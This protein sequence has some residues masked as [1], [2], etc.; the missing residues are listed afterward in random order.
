MS[1]TTKCGCATVNNEPVVVYE[2]YLTQEQVDKIKSVLDTSN[3]LDADLNAIKS[4]IVQSV[5][6]NG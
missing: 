1:C 5:K 6:E 4:A 3:T 2:L